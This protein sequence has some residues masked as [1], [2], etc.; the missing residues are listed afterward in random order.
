MYFHDAT[1][2]TYFHIISINCVAI[3]YIILKTAAVSVIFVG[4]IFQNLRFVMYI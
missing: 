3:L 1:M 2:L 4:F